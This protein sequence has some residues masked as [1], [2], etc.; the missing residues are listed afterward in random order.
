MGRLIG[1]P[2]ARAARRNTLHALQAGLRT[3][4]CDSRLSLIEAFPCRGTVALF[5]SRLIY[6]CGGSVGFGSRMET[7]PTS[8]FIP[9]ANAAGTPE[10]DADYVSPPECV[11]AKSLSPGMLLLCRCVAAALFQ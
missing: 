7:A 11:K 9:L 6:R 8:R 5:Q 10:H 3:H 2:S 1:N 4:E